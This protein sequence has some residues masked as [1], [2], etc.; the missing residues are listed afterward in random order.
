[1]RKL[2]GEIYD[3]EYFIFHKKSRIAL[4]KASVSIFILRFLTIIENF[5]S[6]LQ[7]NHASEDNQHIFCRQSKIS[8]P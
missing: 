4:K 2:F 6:R 1:M 3:K 8:S 7:L 5:I